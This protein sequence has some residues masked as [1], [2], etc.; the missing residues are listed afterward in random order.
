MRMV[1]ETR[2]QQDYLKVKSGFDEILFRQLLPIFPPV[3]LL[4]FDGSRPGDLVSMKMNFLLF[5][6]RWTSQITEE[7]TTPQGFY[8]VDEGVELPVFLHKWT[9][10]HRVLSSGDGSI[11]R[12]EIE[13]EA[14]SGL[15]TYALFPFLWLQ[16]ALRKPIYRR[17]FTRSG[18]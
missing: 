15:M 18:G 2:V 14:P 11:I 3:T 9:H 5:R 4:R 10:K 1:L 17:R 13:F 7:L 12:D 6:Q 8:F 16:F